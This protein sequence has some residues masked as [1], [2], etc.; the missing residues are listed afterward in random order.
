MTAQ[1]L[2]IELP[3]RVPDLLQLVAA[4]P[5][6]YPGLLCSLGSEHGAGMDVLFAAPTGGIAL[7]QGV[8]QHVSG[9][10]SGAAYAGGNTFLPALDAW[11]ADEAIPSNVRSGFEGGW[12]VYL[13]YELA[14]EIEPSV[15]FNY[16]SRQPVA[17]A[18]RC[19]AAFVVERG[20]EPTARLIVERDHEHL[21]P[22][23]KRDY[24]R[25]QAGVLSLGEGV[26]TELAGSDP[27]RFVRSVSS[28]LAAIRAGDIY[29]ANLSRQWR[30]RYTRSAAIELF[31]ALR[32]SN[33]APFS[34]LLRLP[35]I[36]ILSSS[37]ERLV[38]VIGESVSTR[39]IAGTRP[40]GL[41]PEADRALVAELIENPKERAEH[42]MLIDLE[43][44]DLGRICKA[45]SVTVDEYMSVESYRHV[46]HIVSNV[47]GS[48]LPDS[49]PGDVIRALFPGGTITGCPKV[50]CMQ[51]IAALEN[52]ARGP[53][54]GSLGYLNRSGNLDLNILI[55]TVSLIDNEVRLS[56]G[57]GIVSDSNPQHELTETDA[58]AQ[59]MLRALHWSDSHTGFGSRD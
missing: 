44:N 47:T 49:T 12:C 19:P 30:G 29:Q 45:G 54:T 16:D 32:R 48:L 59:G 51:I 36:D 7:R 57:A 52:R 41:T 55:R 20:A 58:K 53:Y 56:A 43:R 26:S 38:Q 31:H 46:H 42:V 15:V 50:R 2:S 14:G 25:A 37:P 13:A 39:P 6:R 4:R 22:S 28:A 40:R 33:P 8:D 35:E 3:G 11:C 18:L 10:G 21:L 24:L 34:A 23:L 5:D 27:E 1:P 9:W 17:V